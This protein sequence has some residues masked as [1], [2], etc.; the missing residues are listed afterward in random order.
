M[1]R[2]GVWT[3]RAFSEEAVQVLVAGGA[4]GRWE[5]RQAGGTEDGLSR[6]VCVFCG[7]S[8]GTGELWN[9]FEDVTK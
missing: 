5:M 4:W 7:G 8:E 6:G 1:K 3:N 9:M 2:P